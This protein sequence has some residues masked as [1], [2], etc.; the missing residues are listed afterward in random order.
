MIKFARFANPNA[1][2]LRYNTWGLVG[3]MP[4]WE[5]MDIER[6]LLASVRREFFAEFYEVSPLVRAVLQLM[7]DWSTGA[8]QQYVQ[9]SIKGDFHL[10]LDRGDITSGCTVTAL[11]VLPNNNYFRSRSEW[12][13]PRYWRGSVGRGE[14]VLEEGEK[15][16][17]AILSAV[18]AAPL[19]IPDNYTVSGLA[20]YPA[21]WAALQRWWRRLGP[22][23]V[24]SEPGRPLLFGRAFK[25][26]VGVEEQW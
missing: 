22:I 17:F 20:G 24:C 16:L 21:V 19:I 1:P 4:E 11:A 8:P 15:K 23:S 12:P 7:P 3:L 14:T 13:W 25:K 5:L 26:I 18:Y 9:D 2:T 10:A 6:T